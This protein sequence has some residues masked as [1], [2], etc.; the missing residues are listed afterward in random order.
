VSDRYDAAKA[1]LEEHRRSQVGL[2][3]NLFDPCEEVINAAN[4]RDRAIASVANSW[5]GDVTKTISAIIDDLARA[6]S[7]FSVDDIRDRLHLPDTVDLRV[8]GA[9]LRAKARAGDLEA[10]GYTPSRYRHASPVR[11]R[12]GSRACT[13]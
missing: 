6:K 11:L 5:R 4:E 3:P 13:A 10:V 12:R 7:E 1:V 9:V 2:S 8:I